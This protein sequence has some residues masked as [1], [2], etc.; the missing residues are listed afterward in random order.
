MIYWKSLRERIEDWQ[1][2][3]RQCTPRQHAIR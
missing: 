1:Q 2:L 3:S